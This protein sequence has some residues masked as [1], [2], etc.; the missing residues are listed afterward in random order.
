MSPAVRIYR[1]LLRLYPPK[2]RRRF[3]T[4]MMDLFR[5]RLATSTVG[6]FWLS[7]AQDFVRTL[8]AAWFGFA[9]GGMQIEHLAFATS[10]SMS[11][12]ERFALLLRDLRF[13]AR[14]LRRTPGFTIVAIA[15]LGLGVGANAAMFSVVNGV[16]LV[17]L[18]FPEPQQL[19]VIWRT[20]ADRANT[21]MPM[22]QPDIRDIQSE[23]QVLRIA[24]FDQSDVTV[25]GD[26][27]P[28]V[29]NA[30][31]VTDGLFDILGVTPLHGRDIRTGENVPDGPRVVVVGHAFWQER[32]GGRPDVVGTTVELSGR[33]YEVVG[34]APPEFTF[35]SRS[36]LWLPR[37]LDTDGCGRGWEVCTIAA[38]MNR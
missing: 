20:E 30:A 16:M 19:F 14:S 15:T 35:P 27:D 26:G 36:Q 2:F 31:R 7:V 22:S 25:T 3:E 38:G 24:G 17:P 9:R 23:V 10:P 12:A 13:A 8:P 32:L 29:V 5:R 37:Y 33:L 34:V 21:S 6:Q 1:L 18:P 4:E 28:A 11:L